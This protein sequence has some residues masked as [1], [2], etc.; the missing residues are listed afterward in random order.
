MLIMKKKRFL[1]LILALLMSSTIFA[2]CNEDSETESSDTSITESSD[3][4][5]TEPESSEPEV[6]AG[7]LDHLDDVDL[8]KD[9]Y[10]LVNTQTDISNSYR[11]IEICPN[12]DDER[13]TYMNEAVVERNRLIE[14]KLG[15]RIREI[16]TTTMTNDIINAV[17]SNSQN[18]QIVCPWMTVAGPLVA[19]GCFYDLHT[20]DDI[21]NFDKPY[22]DNNANESLSINNKL[23]FTTGDFSLLSMDVT[24]CM[25]FNRDMIAEN[26]LENPYDLVAEGKWTL[27]KM[28]EMSHAVTAE[29]DGESGL[30]WKDTIGAHLSTNFANSFFIGAGE[31]FVR[32]DAD[33]VPY[34][35][36]YSERSAEVVEKIKSVF[37]SPDTITIESYFTQSKQEGFTSCYWAARDALANKRTLFVAISLSNVIDIANTYDCK[38]GLLVTPKLNEEQ[39]DYISYIS[40]I[41]ASCCAIPSCNED[42]KTAALVLEALNAASA[43]TTKKHYYQRV[44]KAQKLQDEEGEQMLDIIFNNRVYDLGA[45]FDWGGIRDFLNSVCVDGTDMF[46]SKYESKR[47]AIESAMNETLNFAS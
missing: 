6:S 7:P 33:D 40:V 3:V 37:Q 31:R 16:R 39:D 36:I 32:K 26:N 24:H 2:A 15:V 41:F 17:N 1:S 46:T 47:D 44:L 20:F 11:S 19:S 18:F 13:Y 29:T 30:T 14:E 5:T 12:E 28:L 21:I 27:D 35:A 42:P 45:I 23:Y 4:S 10:F 38:F 9:I 8:D 34:I 25:V 22:W 43:E